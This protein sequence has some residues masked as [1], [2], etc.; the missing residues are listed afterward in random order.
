MYDS[1]IPVYVT[2]THALFWYRQ[3][4]SQL[5]PAADAVFRLACVVGARILVATSEIAE[6]YYL[7]R[8]IGAA[9]TPFRLH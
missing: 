8:K 2:D 7:I 1:E 9:Q 4:P 3:Q 6:Q 5:S